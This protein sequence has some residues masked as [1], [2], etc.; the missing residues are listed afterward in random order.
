M[1][2]GKLQLLDLVLRSSDGVKLSSAA[3]QTE[4]TPTDGESRTACCELAAS[5]EQTV[6]RRGVLARRRPS[7]RARREG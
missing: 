7:A 3:K 5:L 2:E 1:L 6:A 4:A